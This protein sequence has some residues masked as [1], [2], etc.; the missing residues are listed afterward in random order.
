MSK[1][2][3]PMTF[4]Y[5]IL[6]DSRFLL[7]SPNSNETTN[8]VASAGTLGVTKVERKC[9]SPSLADGLD[10]ISLLLLLS[11][12]THFALTAFFHASPRRSPIF[13]TSPQPPHTFHPALS[14]RGSLEFHG[15]RATSLTTIRTPTNLHQRTNDHTPSSIHEAGPSRHCI[16]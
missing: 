7:R 6:T 12:L 15:W 2:S 16:L 14:R 8:E 9:V 1:F 10:L 3:Y 4:L 13:A 11:V 5:L